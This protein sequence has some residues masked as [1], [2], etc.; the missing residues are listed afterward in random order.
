MFFK[1]GLKM[2]LSKIKVLLNSFAQVL[3]FAL[4]LAH[5]P[6]EYTYPSGL[7][8]LPFLIDKNCF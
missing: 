1:T 8:L 3:K 4:S 5:K 2:S 7:P 6:N